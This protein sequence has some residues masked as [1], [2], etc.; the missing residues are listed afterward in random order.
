MKEVNVP[1][2]VS[3]A[4]PPQ[5]PRG[6]KA[7]DTTDKYLPLLRNAAEKTIRRQSYGATFLKPFTRVLF[8]M[9]EVNVPNSVSFA[10]PPQKPRGDKATDTTDKYLPLLRNA[11]EKTI[12]RQSYGAT[13]LKPFGGLCPPNPP[14]GG[15]I[16]PCPPS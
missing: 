15:I 13:F 16:P 9:K 10:L 7:T 4:L 5:K 1:N 11:A 12:R 6:D 2:S 14:Q 8:V 3:F